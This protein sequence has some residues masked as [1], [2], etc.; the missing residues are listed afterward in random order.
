MEDLI[1]HL[2]T[3]LEERNYSS[4]WIML[5]SFNWGPLIKNNNSIFIKKGTILYHQGNIN[6]YLYIVRSG[7]LRL[8]FVDPDGKEKCICIA[9]KGSMLGEV[10]IIDNIPNYASAFAIVN[11]S[12]YKITKE[13]FLY[14]T[15]RN[16]LV[17]NFVM[18]NLVKKIRLMN[19]RIEYNNKDALSRIA[20]SLL[21]LCISHGVKYNNTIKITIKFT[22]EELANLTGLNRVT[23]SKAFQDFFNKKIIFKENGF[24]IIKD[25]EQLKNIIE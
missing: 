6:K 22:H 20:V 8:F 11:T 5:D 13:D 15:S 7:R 14:Y 18:K 3:F 19:S 4:P 23:V 10:S 17:S 25:I 24:I 1:K 16:A 9:E 12:V 2:Q 21:S